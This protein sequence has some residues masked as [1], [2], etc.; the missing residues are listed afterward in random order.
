MK[1][2]PPGVCLAGVQPC[3]VQHCVSLESALVQTT[4]LS[5]DGLGPLELNC[6]IFTLWPKSLMQMKVMEGY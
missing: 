1:L 3:P 6:R 4:P 5:I 2:L